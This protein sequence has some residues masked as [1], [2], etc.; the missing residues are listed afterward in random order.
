MTHIL[1]R[2]MI[3]SL[4]FNAFYKRKIFTL[5]CTAVGLKECFWCMCVCVDRKCV[6]MCNSLFCHYL[7]TREENF[8]LMEPHLFPFPS[9]I[10]FLISILTAFS[11]SLYFYFS[12]TLLLLKYFLLSFTALMMCL[13][14]QFSIFL[15]YYKVICPWPALRW[16]SVMGA[17]LS[18]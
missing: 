4:F 9:F 14:E 11:S 1:W 3:I 8:T 6:C 5:P 12:I 18:L 17:V 10:W 15:I 13:V 7:C 2:Y 16:I